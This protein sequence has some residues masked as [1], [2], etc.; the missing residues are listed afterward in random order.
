MNILYTG[1][2]RFPDKDAA[3]KRVANIINAIE[4]SSDIEEIYVAGWEQGDK[5]E[6]M[7]GR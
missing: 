6:K 4:D 2:F 5:T 7:L 3:G 1:A